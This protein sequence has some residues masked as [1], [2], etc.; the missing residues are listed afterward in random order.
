MWL[1]VAFTK[2]GDQTVSFVEVTGGLNSFIMVDYCYPG[3]HILIS[4]S[5]YCKQEKRSDPEDIFSATTI[6]RY[7]WFKCFRRLIINII[8]WPVTR[9]RKVWFQETYCLWLQMILNDIRS[10][11]IVIT[12]NLENSENVYLILILS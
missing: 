5:D 6:H 1:F 11:T 8:H 2:M 10:R 7:D 9:R 12:P 3:A 4:W